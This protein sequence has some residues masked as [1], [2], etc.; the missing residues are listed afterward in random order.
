MRRKS[1]RF[2]SI[3]FGILI[4]GSIGFGAT[5]AF[6]ETRPL[7]GGCPNVSGC[8]YGGYWN[9]GHLTCCIEW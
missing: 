1:K 6:A 2:S 9:N 5:Q 7:A 4:L 3:A 8:I